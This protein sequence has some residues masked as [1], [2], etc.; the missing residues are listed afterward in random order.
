MSRNSA[1]KARHCCIIGLLWLFGCNGN[2]P[3]TG[4]IQ[5]TQT[6]GLLTDIPAV[7]LTAEKILQHPAA[8]ETFNNARDIAYNKYDDKIYVVDS[9]ND[10]I[11]VFDTELSYIKQFGRYG[12]GPSEFNDPAGIAF[13]K[14]FIAVLD[15]RNFRIQIFDT[16]DGEYRYST[17]INTG[18]LEKDAF[19][20]Y[21]DIIVDSKGRIYVNMPDNS[22]LIHV[23]DRNGRTPETFGKIISSD[24]LTLFS[25]NSFLFTID[26]GDNIYCAFLNHPVLRKYDKDRRLVFEV[27]YDNLPEA[28]IIY[29]GWEAIMKRKDRQD[30]SYT[31]KTYTTFLSADD[32]S[33][34]VNL[35]TLNNEHTLYAF[36]RQTGN[37]EKKIALHYNDL[38]QFTLFDFQKKGTVYAY[39]PQLNI[40]ALFHIAGTE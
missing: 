34:Y 21:S 33:I 35:R 24:D 29:Q 31:Y 23:L 17:E 18:T 6:D 9:G 25:H 36:S 10:R 15:L 16:I 12:Q 14:D 13:Y 20:R 28:D 32:K 1:R 39:S 11:V 2:D 30:G 4:P 19:Y 27:A 7:E 8:N 22:G 37:P 40:I 38:R 26:S 5:F 3:E